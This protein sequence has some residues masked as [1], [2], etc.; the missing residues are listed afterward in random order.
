MTGV[1]FCVVHAGRVFRPGMLRGT[2][3]HLVD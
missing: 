3:T 2:K 1:E